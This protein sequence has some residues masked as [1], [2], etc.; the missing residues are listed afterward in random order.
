MLVYISNL[1]LN[2]I[3]LTHWSA[4]LV[5]SKLSVEEVDGDM[6]VEAE[7]YFVKC[8]EWALLNKANIMKNLSLENMVS[9]FNS[10]ATIVKS[11]G[12]LDLIVLIQTSVAV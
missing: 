4:D 9:P 3:I 11:K 2:Q 5:K 8:Q 6:S 1:T 12:I 7:K 10:P